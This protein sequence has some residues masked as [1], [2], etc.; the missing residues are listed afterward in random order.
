MTAELSPT[1]LADISI[2]GEL[3][4][5]ALINFDRLEQAYYHP[6]ALWKGNEGW[7]GDLEGR[8][9]L[10]WVMLT[11]ATQRQARYLAETLAEF[12]A[13]MNDDGYFGD[14]LQPDAICEQ[15]LS[16]HGWV[17]RALCEH[18]QWSHSAQTL[19]MLEKMVRNLVLPTRGAHADYP[20]DP[21]ARRHEGSHGGHTLE[22]QGRWQ[23]STDTGCDFIFLDGVV[24]AYE[25]LRDPALVEI[26]EE[27]I[28]RYLQVDLL[29]IKAQ[30]HAT[31]TGMRALLR[32]ARLSGRRDLLA[33]VEER[34]RLYTRYGQTEQFA[35]WNWFERPMW[36][37]PCAVVDSLLVALELWRIT[38]RPSYLEDAHL[39][40]FNGLGHEQRRNGGFG[41][42]TCLGAE[43]AWDSPDWT[44][45]PFLKISVP[46]APW[47]CTMRGSD[48][49]AAVIAAS[50]YAQNDR[51]YLPFYGD[52]TATIRL[53]HATITLKQ[54][55]GYP[56]D[57]DVRLEI[58][59]VLGESETVQFNLFT[60]SWSKAHQ[61]RWNGQ[62]CA[63]NAQDG[64]LTVSVTPGAG[65]V[66]EMHCKMELATYGP[67]NVHTPAPYYTIRRGPLLLGVDTR[68]EITL[69]PAPV[70][71]PEGLAG[72]RVAGSEIVLSPINDMLARDETKETYCRQVLFA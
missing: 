36:T 53:E 38:R 42:D 54:T 37:E 44:F 32:Y 27:I 9:V 25:V 8:A 6:T 40:Y 2:S 65:D 17:L 52:N 71:L 1:P 59:E 35:N 30:T 49:L 20:I 29:S 15:Q 3:A 57:G 21:A 50:Y 46:E 63:T 28:A 33:A 18:Y 39:I 62:P 56:Y 68:D 70:L 31:L 69:G 41:C 10:A 58:L 51:M 19:A 66:L 12:P 34:Y 47:C 67:V 72:A 7:P 55:S 61:L 16:G 13:R 45:T 14:S 4:Q 5:R 60:P 26:I 48:G 64:F 23:L 43:G 11:Q 22:Q 24:H